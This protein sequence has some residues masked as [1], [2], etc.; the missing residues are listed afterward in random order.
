MKVSQCFHVLVCDAPRVSSLLS[1]V[2]QQSDTFLLFFLFK[3]QPTHFDQCTCKMS[4][5]SFLHVL[6]WHYLG[7]DDAV[8]P[9]RFLE[10]YDGSFEF[11]STACRELR[12]EIMDVKV[13][14]MWVIRTW[15]ANVY[16][17]APHKVMLKQRADVLRASHEN[18]ICHTVFTMYRSV[19]WKRKSSVFRCNYVCFLMFDLYWELD[20]VRS[21]GHI[22]HAPRIRDDAFEMHSGWLRGDPRD[23]QEARRGAEA[24]LNYHEKQGKISLKNITQKNRKK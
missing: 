3:V 12:Q 5:A 22:W 15:Q 16:L 21:V 14:T 11:N 13:L 23:D 19:T 9:S 4:T 20:L 18:Y 6:P 8:Y 1:C 7:D 17:S 10:N 2:T 24:P